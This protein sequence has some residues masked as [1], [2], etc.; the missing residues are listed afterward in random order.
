LVKPD[1]VIDLLF[2]FL[3]HWFH[4]VCQEEGSMIRD[5]YIIAQE[6]IKKVDAGLYQ[7]PNASRDDLIAM[8]MA[9]AVERNSKRVFSRWCSIHESYKACEHN[10]GFYADESG[11]EFP[12]ETERLYGKGDWK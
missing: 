10:G 2:H 3:V 7:S 11:Y 5:W 6:A 4:L 1:H 8:A 9:E 12:S